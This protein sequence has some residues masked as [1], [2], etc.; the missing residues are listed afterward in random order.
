MDNSQAY[1]TL[2]PEDREDMR[3][4]AHRMVDDV[5]MYLESI[6][7]QPVWRAMPEEVTAH[8]DTDA[9]HEPAG[10][11]ASEVARIDRELV[12]QTS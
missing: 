5:I 7:E 8:F 2:A 4:P 6:G 10:A 3:A 11:L 12:A 9:P 1:E